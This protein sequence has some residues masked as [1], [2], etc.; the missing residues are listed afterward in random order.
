MAN[1]RLSD[2]DARRGERD[3]HRRARLD[4]DI[5][6]IL[7]ILADVTEAVELVGITRPPPDP[8]RRCVVCGAMDCACPQPGHTGGGRSSSGPSD[9][10]LSTWVRIEEGVLRARRRYLEVIRAVE[11]LAE[12]FG[13]DF[14]DR[15]EP[16]AATINPDCP[17]CRPDDHP[18]DC[19]HGHGGRAAWLRPDPDRPG[20]PSTVT[21]AFRDAAETIGGCLDDVQDRWLLALDDGE[22]ETTLQWTA[23]SVGRLRAAAQK[24]LDTLITPNHPNAGRRPKPCECDAANCVPIHYDGECDNLPDG[25]TKCSSCRG[26]DRTARIRAQGRAS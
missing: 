15:L 6:H 3:E 14:D 16:V 23:K 20:R 19:P 10:T 24:V 21:V 13:L 18:D 2:Y 12:Q 26:R 5:R 7:G 25:R 4:R 17:D 1:R 22:S 9:P 11:Q 8:D